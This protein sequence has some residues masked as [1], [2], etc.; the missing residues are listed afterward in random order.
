MSG[1]WAG[2]AG[3]YEEALRSE[4][5]LARRSL[6]ARL[7]QCSDPTERQAVKKELEDLKRNLQ[8]RL[9]KIGR[10]RFGVG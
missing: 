6:K 10:C 4:Y 7:K 3:A 2:G 8:S 1:F 9:Q 5:K